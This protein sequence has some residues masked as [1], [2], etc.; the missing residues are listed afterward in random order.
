MDGP[1][2][3]RR[4]GNLDGATS[5]RSLAGIWH[6][7]M[8][9][10]ST[11]TSTTQRRQTANGRTK[12]HQLPGP[13]DTAIDDVWAFGPAASCVKVSAGAGCQCQCQGKL[14]GTMARMG[15]L[16]V[17]SGRAAPDCRRRASLVVPGQI[18]CRGGLGML[19]YVTCW[20]ILMERMESLRW[21]V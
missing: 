10:G 4:C 6:L 15:A 7:G 20:V 16:G 19:W 9:G 12:P 2:D 5:A 13:R 3:G 11:S 21:V 1:W 14:P 17:R 18:E 8:M